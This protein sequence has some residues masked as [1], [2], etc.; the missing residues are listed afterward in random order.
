MTWKW[1]LGG[2]AVAVVGWLVYRAYSKA[3]ATEPLKVHT[4][5]S[6]G[7]GVRPTGESAQFSKDVVIGSVQSFGSNFPPTKTAG[8]K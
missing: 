1:I 6:T 2:V 3:E 7:S 4:L 5:D 8:I